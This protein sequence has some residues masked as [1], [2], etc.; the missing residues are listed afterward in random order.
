MNWRLR[1]TLPL[2]VMSVFAGVAAD[3]Q[4]TPAP[5]PETAPPV[6]GGPP[7]KPVVVVTETMQRL[8]VVPIVSGLSHPWGF[9]F[10]PDGRNMLIT[11]RPGRLR[12]VRDGVLDP[13]PVQGVPKVNPN[14]IGGLN[15]VALHPEFAKNQLI[16]LSYSKEGDR[17][18]TLAL[19]RGRFT[20]TELVD[21]RDIFVA[22]AWEPAGPMADGG[23]GTYGG[24][25]LFDRNG[26]LYITVG[27]RDT[28]VLVDDPTIRSRAQTLNNHVGKVLRLRDDGTIPKDNPFVGRAGARAEIYSYGHRNPYGLAFHPESG[29]LWE[30]E[31]GPLGGDELNVI[32]PGRNYG[33][34]LVSMGRN[35]SGIPVSSES[36]W[37][38]GMEM[39]RF[40]WSPS[41]NPTNILFYTG[42]RFAGWRGRLIVSGLGSKQLQV[43]QVNKA[44]N[45]IGRPISILNQLGVRFRNVRQGPDGLLYV[46]TEM[47]LQGNEDV[48][49]ALLRI[50]PADA[51]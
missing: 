18:N 36:W 28:R 11:E 46:L 8:R 4:Q 35:Y 25:M 19:A 20:G 2:L 47:R 29:E 41:V 12:I 3:A 44:G 51:D 16:Y 17:G 10:L 49:G 37:R 6:V 9:V 21:V 13:A 24:R 32:Q 33:W 39:P 45:V 15:D 23:G 43:L 48:D 40:F 1:F 30:C 26:L 27:D 22:D 7:D 5:P 31:F 14:H 34:P 50:E 38:P 42:T